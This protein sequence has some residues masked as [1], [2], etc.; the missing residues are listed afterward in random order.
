MKVEFNKEIESRKETQT[1]I[2]LEMEN[3]GCQMKV[4]EYASPTD[5]KMCTRELQVLKTK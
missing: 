5:C 1:A 2:K 3:L 4:S